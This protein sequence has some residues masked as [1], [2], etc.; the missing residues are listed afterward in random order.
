ME[1][2]IG[3]DGKLIYISPACERVSGY[4][5]S[6]YMADPSLL[7]RIVLDEDRERVTAACRLGPEDAPHDMSFRIRC[8]NGDLRWIAR[9]IR[10]VH[11]SDGRPLGLRANDRDITQLKHAEQLA[12]SLAHADALTGLPNRRMLMEHLTQNLLRAQRFHRPLGLIFIDLN[13]F[14]RVNDQWGH[15]TGD[16]LLRQVAQRLCQCVR[17]SDT[18]ARLGGDEFV[19]LLT[20]LSHADDATR[21][22]DKILQAFVEPVR[23]GEHALIVTMSMGI[24]LPDTKHRQD[25][26]E[27]MA[28]ADQAMYRVKRS[29]QNGW[30]LFREPT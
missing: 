6:D 25:P 20:E 9:G 14:K 11:A 24:T 10:P 19:I 22:A 13:D 12:Q 1:T 7:D 27:V 8:K 3:P 26:R 18:V 4:T 17:A 30:V 16:E 15:D 5:P 23:L 29:G 28:Q 2:W 21:V